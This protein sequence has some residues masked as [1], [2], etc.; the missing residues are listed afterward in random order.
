MAP[1][2]QGCDTLASKACS[3]RLRPAAAQA[4]MQRTCS[5]AAEERRASMSASLKV[6]DASLRKDHTPNTAAAPADH[7]ELCDL[8][9]D[10][11]APVAE[12]ADDG[13]STPAARQVSVRSM[14]EGGETT[15]LQTASG[16]AS[17]A[18]CRPSGATRRSKL[19]CAA[20]QSADGCVEHVGDAANG[21]VFAARA[22]VGEAAADQPGNEYTPAAS[23]SMC[24]T[25]GT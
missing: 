4:D 16:D 10:R 15:A 8:A 13:A 18:E 3:A 7:V 14:S 23:S 9:A 1:A 2:L 11:P 20:S 21:G 19:F 5:E 12:T 24:A 6:A 22:A 25:S 17:L